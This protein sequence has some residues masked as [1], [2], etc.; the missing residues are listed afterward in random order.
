MSRIWVKVVAYSRRS[1]PK[2]ATLRSC[3]LHPARVLL[4]IQQTHHRAMALIGETSAA[5]A[6]I[7][8]SVRHE[9]TESVVISS[10][11]GAAIRHVLR[12]L[13]GCLQ[14]RTV[15][16]RTGS[17]TPGPDFVSRWSDNIHSQT[18][19]AGMSA[20]VLM[21]AIG[22]GT[23]TIAR[24]AAGAKE[25]GARGDARRPE[26][27]CFDAAL[28]RR[29]GTI[30]CIRAAQKTGHRRRAERRKPGHQL[31]PGARSLFS[32]RPHGRAAPAV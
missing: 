10:A 20:A 5:D 24:M 23:G 6:G 12:E 4:A 29:R 14:T 18:H 11:R 1:V 2:F 25:T 30:A 13:S 31:P 8:F 21:A 9:I 7:S 28:L 15:C 16:P 17:G 19:F 27:R 3:R 26:F 32:G 22:S